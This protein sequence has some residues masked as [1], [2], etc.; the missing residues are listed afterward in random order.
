M[1][2]GMILPEAFGRHPP[3]IPALQAPRQSGGKG[4]GAVAVAGIG[5]SDAA[6]QLRRAVAVE[7][8]EHHLPDA[9]APE[10]HRKAQLPPGGVVLLRRL[11]E[12][13]LRGMGLLLP[14]VVAPP[15]VAPGI[16]AQGGVVSAVCRG[17]GIQCQAWGGKVGPGWEDVTG[18]RPPPDSP[19]A[20]SGCSTRRPHGCAH[21]R[22]WRRP[23]RR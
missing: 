23:R 8:G 7:V 18:H 12:P 21:S 16:P 14:V 6:A 17:Q 11:Q 3:Q 15:A 19:P 22:G 13:L 20:P 4:L 1:P 5:G 10:P 2:G 9:P